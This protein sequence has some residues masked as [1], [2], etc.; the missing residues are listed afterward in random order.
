MDKSKVFDQFDSDSKALFEKEFKKIKRIYVD[1]DA[2]QDFRLGALLCK[3]T[4]DREYQ[5][6]LEHIVPYEDAFDKQVMKYFPELDYIEKEIPA[7]TCETNAD[8]LSVFSP[9]TSLYGEFMGALTV[10][11][12]KNQ[13]GDKTV[14][15]IH[16]TFNCKN[17]DYTKKERILADLYSVNNRLTVDFITGGTSVLDDKLL[18][19]YDMLI[20]DSLCEFM[21]DLKIAKMVMSDG[22]LRDAIVMCNLEID[23]VHHTLNETELHNKVQ[24][25]SA[26]LN[27]LFDL[28]YVRKKIMR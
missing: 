27:V 13:I 21:R 14:D 1:L 17:F 26:V 28:T 11:N 20:L 5:Y 6:I 2:I 16:I 24:Q 25:T 15:N 19:S 12:D 8:K 10:I 3:I 4:T 9:M 7:Y 18:G 23:E 22:I